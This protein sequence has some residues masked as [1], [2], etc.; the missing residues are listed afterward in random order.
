MKVL[1]ICL[2]A[3]MAGASFAAL[4]C[5]DWRTALGC[6]FLTAAFTIVSDE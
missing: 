5:S 3:G 1:W 6:A 2:A 4:F